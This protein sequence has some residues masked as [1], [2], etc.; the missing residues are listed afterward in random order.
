MEIIFFTESDNESRYKIAAHLLA[1]YLQKGS[2][3]VR[4]AFNQ[5]YS[6]KNQNY[7]NWAKH[8]PYRSMAKK[9][10]F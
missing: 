10:I 4:H 3:E 7:D 6:M 8:L 5:W 1:L 2:I 9:P